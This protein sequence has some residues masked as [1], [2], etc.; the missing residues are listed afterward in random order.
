MVVS[1]DFNL[2]T[3][4]LLV[5]RADLERDL[6]RREQYHLNTD[7]AKNALLRANAAI[8]ALGLRFIENIL[9]EC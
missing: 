8:D 4:K 9:K 3:L 7:N 6:R 2:K 1:K 5:L